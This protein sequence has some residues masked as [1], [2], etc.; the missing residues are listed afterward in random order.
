MY[1]ELSEQLGCQ[2]YELFN[3]YAADLYPGRYTL[4]V[5]RELADMA[6]EIG[7]LARR[8]GSL[9]VA[10][11]YL[12][13]EFHELA[14]KVGDSLGLSFFVR[15][16]GA[17]R[18][19]FQSVYFM[20]ETAKIIV[21]DKARVYVSDVPETLGCSLVFGTDH[22]WLLNWKRDNPGG[23]LV[24]YV[25]SDAYTKSI[26]DFISTSRN[27]DR[28]IMYALKNYPGRKIL[29]LPDKFLGFVMKERALNALRAE[30]VVVDPDLI[31]VYTYRKDGWGACCYVHEQIGMNVA[32]DM[33][34]EYPDAELMIHPE[35]GCAS[36]CLYKMQQGII[37]QARAYFLST[38][39]MLE[40]AQASDKKQFIVATE[41]GMIYRL[42]KALPEKEFI[43]ISANAECRFM[44][45]NTF[46]K[47]RASL[48]SDRYEI[49][50][51]DDCCDPKK[52]YI[53]ASTIHIQR[54]VAS[55]AS[56]GILRMLTIK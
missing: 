54:R 1:R 3:R 52:P 15:D 45:A 31:E 22:E 11:N 48:L 18:V 2:W 10:H 9:V 13:P 6:I 38:E 50:M 29:V 30:G 49:V 26:S 33:L 12:Y 53:D 40:R 32:E 51:C 21:G 56:I 39:A 20:G 43:S 5:C 23:L 16:A 8:K 14:D 47:L 41:K 4:T 24:T 55:R 46:A 34:D 17:K 35:C 27:T 19:D 7:Y 28:I 25:N 37:P 44:K 36:A 42:R